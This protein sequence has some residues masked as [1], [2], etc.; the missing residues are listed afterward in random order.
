MRSL[1]FLPPAFLKIVAT[2]LA[3]P[4]AASYTGHLGGGCDG[5]TYGARQLT[6]SQEENVKIA[7][8]TTPAKHTGTCHCGAVTL[9]IAVRPEYLNDCN[10]SLCTKLGA[11]W[12]YF[13][14][15]E[16][17]ISGETGTYIRSDLKTPGLAA[18]FCKRCGCTTHWK[19]L[20]VW[21][22]DRMGVNMRLFSPAA[23]EGI[24]IRHPDGR[25]W[26]PDR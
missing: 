21:P 14:P 3:S 1:I 6:Q 7:S 20:P 16:V 11:L 18:H 15:A 12:G 9:A 23:V 8:M 4:S 25:A 17:T 26:E 19:P 24:E 2:L 5:S 10:C 22:Q 13:N